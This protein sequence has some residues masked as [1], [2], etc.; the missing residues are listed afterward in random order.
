VAVNLRCIE[1]V[2]VDSDGQRDKSGGG[3]VGLDC[4]TDSELTQLID[5]GS[6]ILMRNIGV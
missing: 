6:I 1:A 3:I 5:M 2:E 4:G